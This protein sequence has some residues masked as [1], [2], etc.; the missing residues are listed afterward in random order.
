M[1]W[2]LVIVVIGPLIV[3]IRLIAE[4]WRS[5]CRTASRTNLRLLL[6]IRLR[7]VLLLLWPIVVVVLIVVTLIVVVVVVVRGSSEKV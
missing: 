7:F 4:S 5:G 3:V 6:L 1:L 2:S